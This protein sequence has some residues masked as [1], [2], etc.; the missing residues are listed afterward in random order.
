MR[1]VLHEQG[2]IRSALL[3]SGE[4]TRTIFFKISETE[5]GKSG[6]VLLADRDFAWI[7]RCYG[8]SPNW[9]EQLVNFEQKVLEICEADLWR[10]ANPSTEV[11]EEFYRKWWGKLVTYW[12]ASFFFHNMRSLI[13]ATITRDEWA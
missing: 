8:E 7:S 2:E 10:N 13:G 5:L 11:K 3:A 4:F 1:Q 9:R 6:Q 12:P